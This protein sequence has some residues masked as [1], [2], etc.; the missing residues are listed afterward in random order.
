MLGYNEGYSIDSI[1]AKGDLQLNVTSSPVAPPNSASRHYMQPLETDTAI[2]PSRLTR[3]RYSY[4]DLHG[5]CTQ[6]TAG[7]MQCPLASQHHTLDPSNIRNITTMPKTTGPPRPCISAQNFP[8]LSHFY[9][10][11]SAVSVIPSQITNHKPQSIPL[12][13]YQHKRLNHHGSPSLRPLGRIA[14]AK[15][16]P[17]HGSSRSRDHARTSICTAPSFPTAA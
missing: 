2:A 16:I 4:L 6:A 1:R 10:S 17:M 11:L 3:P 7:A 13:R 5:S 9:S 15:L 14:T 8:K 12:S